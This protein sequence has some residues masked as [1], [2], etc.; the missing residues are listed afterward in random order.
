MKLKE[1]IEHQRSINQIATQEHLTKFNELHNRAQE[2]TS[3][4]H[5]VAGDEVLFGLLVTKGGGTFPLP[6]GTDIPEFELEM[7]TFHEDEVGVLYED[8]TLFSN[9]SATWLAHMAKIG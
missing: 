9:E 2:F 7:C 5:V 3:G 1:S 6:S 4:R 8:D